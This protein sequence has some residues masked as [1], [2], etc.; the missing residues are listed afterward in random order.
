[1]S[2]SRGTGAK[3]DKVYNGKVCQPHCNFNVY[4]KASNSSYNN[5]D[6]I[7]N[8]VNPSCAYIPGDCVHEKSVALYKLTLGKPLVCPTIHE[9]GFVRIDKV[10]RE[11]CI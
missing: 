6:D 8:S 2:H 4:R 3:R 1:M 7:A 11:K 10:L 5:R 9:Q